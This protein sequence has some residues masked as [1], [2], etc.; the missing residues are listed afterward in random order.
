MFLDGREALAST[1]GGMDREGQMKK[2]VL[3][4]RS[5]FHRFSDCGYGDEPVF[6]AWTLLSIAE[7]I[8]C[9]QCS[10]FTEKNQRKCR[11]ETV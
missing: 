4:P 10:F 3:Q 11:G 1:R 5:A 9:K 8:R 2:S 7:N 6:F